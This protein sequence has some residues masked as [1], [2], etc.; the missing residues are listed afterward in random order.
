[1]VMTAGI[2]IA[3]APILFI[4]ALL[5]YPENRETL[6]QAGVNISFLPIAQAGRDLA[7]ASF[8]NQDNAD[9]IVDTRQNPDELM[10]EIA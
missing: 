5:R 6:Q 1:M 2:K 3:T 8:S 10:V 4:K 7:Q 9:M